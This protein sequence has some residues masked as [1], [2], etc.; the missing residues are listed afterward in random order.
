ML[1]NSP[2]CKKLDVKY[3]I[4]GLV[5]SVD[6]MVAMGRAARALHGSTNC[7]ALNRL[8]ASLLLSPKPPC[9]I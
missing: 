8:C 4:F 2:I 7:A 9:T 3:P 1:T 6:V 5:H